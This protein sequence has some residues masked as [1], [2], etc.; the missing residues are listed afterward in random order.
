VKRLKARYVVPSI[1]FAATLVAPPLAATAA[2]PAPSP[3]DQ[4]F[5][6]PSAD[7]PFEACDGLTVHVSLTGS[8]ARIHELKNG[9]VIT[10]GKGYTLTYTNVATG[11]SVTIKATGSVQK[12]TV[13]GATTTVQST[14]SNGVILFSSDTPAG[15]STTQYTGRVVYTV[16]SGGN[17]TIQ[18]TSGRQRDICAELTA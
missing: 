17:F 8:K 3:P 11:K 18:S 16:D 4:D 13:N 15:P 5:T 7:I 2:Q 12:V 6:L 9:V 10:A 14:G 1:L